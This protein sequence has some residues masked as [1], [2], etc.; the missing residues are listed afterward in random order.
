MKYIIYSGQFEKGTQEQQ[1]VFRQLLGSQNVQYKF[2]LYFHWYNIIHEYGHCLC[3]HYN[4]DIIGLK[5]E[6]LVNR[7]AVSIWQYAGYEQE[8]NDL[9]KMINETL[10]RMKDPVPDHMS[11]T[12]YYEQIWGTEELMQVPIYGY[13]QFKS[14]QMALENKED[15]ET[16][17]T[18]IGIRKGIGNQS[19][20]NK[21]YQISADTAKEVLH[22]IRYLLDGLGIEQ[23]PVDVELVDDPS[24][25][26]AN[27]ID[28]SKS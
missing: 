19:R 3:E 9:Q 5:Q 25:Q 4:S 28:S 8:L 23:P 20:I 16:V 15:L 7:F 1:A 17:L 26:C 6:F 14:V 21:K 2:D 22:D 24:I 10:Q 27:C 11:F 12:E 18:E 13:F